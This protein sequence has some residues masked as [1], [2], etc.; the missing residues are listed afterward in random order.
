MSAAAT[1]ARAE[2]LNDAVQNKAVDSS[3]LEKTETLKDFAAIRAVALGY[4]KGVNGLN[5]NL[6]VLTFANG[7]E[8]ENA[9][10]LGD[11]WDKSLANVLVKVAGRS[12]DSVK[13]AAKATGNIVCS[14][15]DNIE[16]TQGTAKFV[17][18]QVLK[19]VE[20]FF[21][22]MKFDNATCTVAPFGRVLE[23]DVDVTLEF[24]YADANFL[25]SPYGK[26]KQGGFLTTNEAAAIQSS[27][28][29][30]AANNLVD[31]F[32]K[33]DSAIQDDFWLMVQESV[34]G[35][36]NVNL[37][38]QYWSKPAVGVLKTKRAARDAHLAKTVHAFDPA[39]LRL[40]IQFSAYGGEAMVDMSGFKEA[41]A[42][43]VWGAHAR[44]FA[45]GPAQ[46]AANKLSTTT[47]TTTRT[48]LVF[49]PSGV[50]ES[51]VPGLDG[52]AKAL[53][54]LRATAY[55]QLT[56]LQANQLGLTG[57]LKRANAT[58]MLACTTDLKSQKCADARD[59]LNTAYEATQKNSVSV[60]KQQAVYD[61]YSTKL[62]TARTR[63]DANG[64]DG[65][66]TPK[67]DASKNDGDDDSSMMPILIGAGAALF[68]I[69]IIAVL[70][71]VMTKQKGGGGSGGGAG[72]DRYTAAFAN[73]MYD[74]PGQQIDGNYGDQYGGEPQYGAQY[75]APMG[76][77]DAGYHGEAVQAAPAGG[78]GDDLYD[79]PE[80]SAEA[81]MSAGGT[82][83][84][85]VQPDEADDENMGLYDDTSANMGYA[86]V[87]PESE[88]DASD[89]DGG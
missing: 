29:Y 88:P 45:V 10:N 28:S 46:E 44:L 67:P 66:V 80:M 71:V 77:F 65:D 53:E 69:V 5:D 8:C 37:D 43:A 58:K 32:E 34:K 30:T 40:Q 20:V 51:S 41:L 57:A 84:L 47:T 9:E 36:T 18:K 56:T 79:E 60:A 50:N 27:L 87:D 12:A 76:N 72:G 61:L 7:T 83:Y 19:A 73:P 78:G 42:V 13:C 3:T 23:E 63:E 1:L 75:G 70:V 86:D 74:Q 31:S 68:L 81:E 6:P 82:G 21:A 25:A 2:Y 22:T 11:A 52:N 4:S 62:D 55:D 59:T 16:A 39:L 54:N 15:M 35:S 48:K 85:D 33:A 24:D 38:D 14:G 49:D 89:D 26:S 17:F 64:G